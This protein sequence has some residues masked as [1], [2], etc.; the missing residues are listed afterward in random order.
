MLILIEKLGCLGTTKS[1]GIFRCSFCLKIYKIRTDVAKKQKHCGCKTKEILSENSLKNWQ[2]QEYKSKQKNSHIELW[3]SEEFKKSQSEKIKKFWETLPDE[4][5]NNRKN[6]LKTVWDNIEYRENQSK[7]HKEYFINNPE[8]KL[9]LSKKSKEL[10]Q[11][12]EFRE[13]ILN[14]YPNRKGE[15]ASNWQGG[16][17]FELYGIEFNKELK[18]FIKQRDNYQC[19]DPNCKHL[20]ERLEVHHIDY[21]KKNN[22]PENLITLCLN[23]HRKTNFKRNYYTEFYQKMV[24]K[25]WQ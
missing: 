15:L 10:W 24:N 5:K 3:N 4:E 11:N 8:S 7:K 19:Q 12:Q 14:S 22:N 25:L 1:W 13:K 2:N 18:N 6:K 17:S 21:D 23:C 20:S 9:N 16:K